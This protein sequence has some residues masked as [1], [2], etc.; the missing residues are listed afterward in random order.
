LEVDEEDAGSH[1]A[2]VLRERESERE[3]KEF[4][5]KGKRIIACQQCS[6]SY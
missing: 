6:Y 5:G 3:T 2:Y 4:D 1:P